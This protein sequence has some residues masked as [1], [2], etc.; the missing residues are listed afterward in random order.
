MPDIA[1]VLKE[2]IR[3]LARSEIKKEVAPLKKRIQTLRKVVTEQKEQIT[4]LEKKL[5]QAS[6]QAGKTPGIPAPT[7]EE[8]TSSARITTASARALRKRLKL[9]QRQMGLL[10][11]VSTMTVLRWEQ[12]RAKPRGENRDAFLV[13]RGMSRPQ[14]LERL[15]VLEE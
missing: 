8:A 1:G 2:E 7:S 12:G 15:E 14:V 3:R 13:L 11:G 4:G 9:T 6:R 10:V 5:A